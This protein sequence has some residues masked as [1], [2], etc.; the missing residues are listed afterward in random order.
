MNDPKYLEIKM[1][2]FVL[3][4]ASI[5]SFQALLTIQFIVNYSQSFVITCNF[6]E[7]H[8]VGFGEFDTC[9]PS[10][11]DTERD[12]FINSVLTWP[13]NENLADIKQFYVEYKRGIF[14]PGNLHQWFPNLE[15][16]RMKKSRVKFLDNFDMK[17]LVKLRFLSL[18]DNDIEVLQVDLF[19]SNTQLEEIYFNNNKLK[20]I[21]SRIL[22][23]L[24]HL[25]AADFRGNICID[26]NATAI[27][28]IDKLKRN[29]DDGCSA[30]EFLVKKNAEVIKKLV[31]F[32][33]TIADLT[34]SKLN[35]EAD[36]AAANQT[37]ATCELENE[38]LN[39]KKSK[40]EMKLRKDSA[41]LKRIQNEIKSIKESNDELTS[42]N[43]M[44]VKKVE[45]AKVEI[46]L[47]EERFEEEFL[48]NQSDSGVNCK[49]RSTET[50]RL[51]FENSRLSAQNKDL[52]AF[53]DDREKE[54]R[55]LNVRCEFV[56]W[57][58]YTCQTNSLKIRID[59]TEI[60]KVEGK[61]ESRKTNEDVK[62]FVISSQDVRT[63]SLPIN[64]GF[65]FPRLKTLIAQNSKIV[66]IQR[67]NFD[68]LNL[69]GLILDHNR[70]IELT[71]DTLTDLENL[72]TLDLSF[73]R[74]EKLHKETFRKLGKLKFVTMNDNRIEKLSAS[75]FKGNLQ[76]EIVSLANNKI[77]YIGSSMLEHL[78]TLK[79]ANLLGNICIDGI[80]TTASI[81][82]FDARVM[83]QCTPPTDIYCKFEAA[84]VSEH[85]S[86]NVVDLLVENE[87][88]MI[89]EVNGMH[90]KGHSN[91]D[92]SELSIVDQNVLN[93]PIGFGK[94]FIKLR[95][96]SV[97]NSKMTTIDVKSF[98]SMSNLKVLSIVKND[99]SL[100][101]DEGLQNLKNLE[102]I[103]MSS[104]KIAQIADRSFRNLGKLKVLMLNGNKLTTL[105]SNLLIDN[106]KLEE[107][108]VRRNK[109]TSIGA[110]L[111]NDL[112]NLK[113][114]DFTENSCINEKFPDSDLQTLK[115][116]I[117]E[118]CK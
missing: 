94:F 46:S 98:K 72:V 59:K 35:L 7:N 108:H 73:N 83:S 105:S 114:A 55:S 61:H 65:I 60:V 93:L 82:E 100:V 103:D 20:F 15:S 64:I 23:P 85:Y 75:T 33:Y 57:D 118:K 62:T 9:E 22:S 49:E 32:N 52:K 67:L 115:L 113:L 36:I 24:R 56:V 18:P 97:K 92:I 8:D 38:T 17:G 80:Y 106:V 12:K 1:T 101:P 26:A 116:K 102:I 89:L 50:H 104:N 107:F 44:L 14:F 90:V 43:V 86:C 109:L 76:L 28:E 110:R 3:T 11:F 95:K 81:K 5:S 91:D 88:T 71:S 53:K 25:R 66:F 63:D 19:A 54:E 74:I 96:F 117:L 87:N 31:D 21:S 37:L 34:L 2:H 30:P 51:K 4:N 16:I 112:G 39:D 42:D 84:T 40:V 41:A 13:L 45:R 58:D 29:L 47:M 27:T 99:I 111:I 70:I 77:K 69:E 68:S 10:I 79:Y 6:G 48:S 78:T